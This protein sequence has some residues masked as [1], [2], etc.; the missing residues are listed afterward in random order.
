MHGEVHVT[1]N[2]GIDALR[3]LMPGTR[4]RPATVETA[5]AGHLSPAGKLGRGTGG[6]R[7]LASSP[8][9]AA[10]DVA[11]SLVLHPNPAV[12][13][14]DAPL[15]R[16]HSKRRSL[17][18][19]RPSRN[20]SSGCATATSSSAIRA[21]CRR[22]PRRSAFRYCILRDRTERPE[23]IASGNVILA[24]RDADRIREPRRMAPRRQDRASSHDPARTAL[25]GWFRFGAYRDR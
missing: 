8:S 3:E 13:R 16:P 7:L 20:A 10:S 19:V 25:W 24:G 2:T 4:A 21:G 11:I 18:A 15:A 14:R 22:R 1:G 9:A 23:G 6:N 12:I 17:R 5:T